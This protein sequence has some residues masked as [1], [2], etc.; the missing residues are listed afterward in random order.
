MA[1]IAI[2]LIEEN[3]KDNARRQM[4]FYIDCMELPVFLG[5]VNKVSCQ[6]NLVVI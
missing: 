3:E 6:Y 1:Y 5:N 4:P 2:L